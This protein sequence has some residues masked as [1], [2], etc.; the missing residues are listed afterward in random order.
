MSSKKYKIEL[1]CNHSKDRDTAV[2][3]NTTPTP[4]C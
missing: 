4:F 1:H 3:I 2:P